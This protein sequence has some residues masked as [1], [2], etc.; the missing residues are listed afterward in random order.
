MTYLLLVIYIVKSLI[1][2]EV[3][4]RVQCPGPDRLQL[5]IQIK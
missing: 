1:L 3:P 5:E 2:Q 4:A